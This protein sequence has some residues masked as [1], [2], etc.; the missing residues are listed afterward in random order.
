MSVCDCAGLAI[1]YSI[2]CINMSV[3]SIA[4]LSNAVGNLSSY[5]FDY[6]P[7]STLIPNGFYN[8]FGS[9]SAN[10][11][12]TETGLLSILFSNYYCSFVNPIF[13]NFD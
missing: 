3:L 4:I 9:L 6:L 10:L 2:P 12:I 8:Y 11:D 1:T 5:L 13:F 7:N